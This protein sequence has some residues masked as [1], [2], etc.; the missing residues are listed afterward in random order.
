ML[1]RLFRIAQLLADRSDARDIVR[2]E[3]AVGEIAPMTF[4]PRLGAG[5]MALVAKEMGDRRSSAYLVVEPV[6]GATDQFDQGGPQIAESL[7]GSLIQLN[8]V[9]TF[10]QCGFGDMIGA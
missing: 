2:V 9:Q 8:E 7:P 3:I 10:F 1:L 4:L 5:H 6:Q